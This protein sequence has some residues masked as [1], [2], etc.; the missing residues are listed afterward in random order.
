MIKN[1]HLS[2]VFLLR[3]SQSRG[4]RRSH[5]WS[6][7]SLLSSEALAKGDAR[8]R[9]V[10]TIERPPCGIVVNRPDRAIAQMQTSNKF[11]SIN[12]ITARGH[13]RDCYDVRN[14]G[15]QLGHTLQL[16]SGLSNPI[17]VSAAVS[18]IVLQ[19]ALINSVFVKNISKNP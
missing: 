8:P 18:S 19:H 4:R 15:S 6:A 16:Y 17:Y 11:V 12:A 9:G 13:R 14:L 10:A 1:G 2:A 7:A 5:L 3:K